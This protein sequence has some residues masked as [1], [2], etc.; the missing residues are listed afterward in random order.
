MTKHSMK[1]PNKKLP[2]ILLDLGGVT[3]NSTGNDIP[4]INWKIISALNHKHGSRMCIGE[5]AFPDFL[6]DYNRQMNMQWSGAKFLEEIWKTLTFNHELVYDILKDYDIYIASDNYKE[7]IDYIGPRF[8]FSEWSKGQYYS[9][10]LACEKGNVE[11]WQKLLD[12]IGIPASELLLIDDSDYKL[13]AASRVG[14][15]G[16]LYKGNDE[17]RTQLSARSS[18]Q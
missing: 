9:C 6:A 11:F 17:L 7:N 15:D 13:E 5:D 18:K 12:H 8:K 1:L 2:T 16:I 4:G 10:D 3:F 14:I